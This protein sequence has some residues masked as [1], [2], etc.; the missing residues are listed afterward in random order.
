MAKGNLRVTV[1]EE[2]RTR[3]K[4]RYVVAAPAAGHMRRIELKPGAKVEAGATLAGAFIELTSKG[5]PRSE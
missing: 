1:D 2:G 3:V 5:G 4:N